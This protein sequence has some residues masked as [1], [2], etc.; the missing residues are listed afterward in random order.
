MKNVQ[1][2]LHSQVVSQVTT[3]VIKSNVKLL[4]IDYQ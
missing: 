1:N 4:L 2:E 3:N